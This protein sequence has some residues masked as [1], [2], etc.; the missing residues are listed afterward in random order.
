M[1]NVCYLYSENST[2][3][4]KNKRSNMFREITKF[5][6][7]KTHYDEDTSSL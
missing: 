7:W 5:M 6:V 4:E 2:N 3:I 1:K